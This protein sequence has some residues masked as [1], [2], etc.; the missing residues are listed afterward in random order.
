MRIQS[1]NLAGINYV[2]AG[3]PTSPKKIIMLHGYGAD[4]LD[5]Y[6]LHDVIDS[7]GSFHW[8]FPNGIIDVP[9]GP[10]MM[11]KGW[12]NI[13]IPAFERLI[14][15]GEFT[16]LKP[17]GIDEARTRLEK[18]L[19]ALNLDISNTYLGGFSQGSMLV[20]EL[21]TESTIK[22]KGVL[23]LSCTLVNEERWLS[24]M[25]LRKGLKYYQSHG[26]QDPILPIQLAEKLHEKLE[27][28]GWDG[29]L[30]VFQGGHEIPQIVIADIISFL[31]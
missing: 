10:Q 13:D 8:I 23:L 20:M 28:N 19:K 14:R 29:F 26:S 24:Q 1:K 3:D 27:E 16:K 6:S 5:L 25:S 2:E 9:I 18:F 17:S 7:K 11:G 21:L 15:L 30:Q 22:P 4:M 12:F 31:R